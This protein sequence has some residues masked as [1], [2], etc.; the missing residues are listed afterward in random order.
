VWTAVVLG[1]HLAVGGVGLAWVLS[2][3][4]GAAVALLGRE[5]HP[6]W[7]LGFL[8]TVGV[9]FVTHALRWRLLLGGLGAHAPLGRLTVFRAAGQS[10]STL[11]PSAKLGGEPLRAFLLV[12]E[13]V[14]AARA[15][16]SVAVD[17]TLEIGA[18][19]P[20]AF[21]YAALLLRRG[22]PELEGALVSVGIGVAALAVGIALTV[23]RLRR[24]EGVVTAVT[25]ST[26]LGRL[27]FVQ[28]HMDVL[29]AAEGDVATLIDQPCLIGRAFVLAV[30]ANALVLV[31]YHLLL[32]AFSLPSSPLAT[33]AAVFATGAA[34]ALPVPAAVGVLEGA[35]MFVLGTLGHPPEVGLAVGLAVRLRELVWVLPGLVYL[36]GRALAAPLARWR[37]A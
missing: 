18:A 26:A 16:A 15:V 32:A 24:R 35:E 2:H 34:H 11:V 19:A 36:A 14:S 10:L 17:R 9:V 5:P 27:R 6:A 31:E 37:V 22:V 23:R 8:A 12:G 21:V 25:R 30:V 3:H 28:Q 29:E 13:R 1:V 4:G 7:L 33:V 20:F